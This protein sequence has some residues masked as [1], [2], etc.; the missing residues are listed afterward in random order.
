MQK[1]KKTPYAFSRIMSIVAT[2]LQSVLS[3]LVAGTFLATLTKSIGISDATTGIISSFV[4]LGSLFGLV[5]IFIPNRKRK[6]FVT[7][8]SVLIF[9]LYSLI[10]L[11]PSIPMP[12][13]WRQLAFILGYLLSCT[14]S[15]IAEPKKS[16]WHISF[17]DDGIRGRFT[18]IRESA[19]L[20]CG[21]AS[22]FVLG[23]VIDKSNEKGDVLGSF[24]AVSLTIGCFSAVLLISLMLC[25]DRVSQ[26]EK[27]EKSNPFHDVKKLLKNK[28]FR[29][30]IGISLIWNIGH[31]ITVPFLASYQISELGFS[32]TYV[33]LITTVSQLIRIAACMVFGYFADKHSFS[34]V[35]FVSLLIQVV[36]FATL[37]F[38]V[39]ANGKVFYL[40]YFIVFNISMAGISSAIVNVVFDYVRES[41]RANAL[42]I[43]NAIY[44]T[45]GFFVTLAISPLVTYIQEN[46]NTFFGIHAYA[47]QILACFSGGIILIAALL[48]RKYLICRKEQ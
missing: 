41:Q 1:A 15:A 43:N 3:V 39:P 20:L 30:I 7:L 47:Q 8:F 44:G 10:Y 48:C 16:A 32:L 21:I 4:A 24:K 35:F 46:G 26:E 13:S 9:T 40:I 14:L 27:E 31:Y 33:A 5:S 25:R 12:T 42:A 38:T 36:S 6:R 37:V 2:S 22:S 18:A 17:V 45:A 34:R 11:V 23:L 29:A 19:S 28:P